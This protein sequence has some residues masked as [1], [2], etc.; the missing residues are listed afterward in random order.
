MAAEGQWSPPR[1]RLRQIDQFKRW[2]RIVL[3]PAHFIFAFGGVDIFPMG[4]CGSH[5]S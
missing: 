4:F 3:K 2:C 1:Q 5:R